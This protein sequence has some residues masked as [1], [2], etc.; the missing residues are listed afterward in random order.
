MTIYDDYL[1][2]HQKKVLEHGEQTC[3]LMQV[4]HFYEVYAVDNQKEQINHENIKRLSEIMNVQITRKNKN[5]IENNRANPIMLGINL[6]SFEKYIQILTNHNYTTV[7]VDQVTEPPEPERK[8]TNT[9]S[10]GTNINYVS[11]GDSSNLLVIYIEESKQISTKETINI[12]L[13]VVDLSIGKTT[14][15]ETYSKTDDKN[16]SLNLRDEVPMS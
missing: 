8:V 6:L 7:I 9:I 10:P 11:N 15:Y 13:S 3:V 2:L 16:I 14:V 12:G 5:K 4:G 1:E